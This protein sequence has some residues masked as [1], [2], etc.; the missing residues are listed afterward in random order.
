LIFDLGKTKFDFNDLIT[1]NKNLMGRYFI[2]GGIQFMSVLSLLFLIILS[3]AVFSVVKGIKSR[4][5]SSNGLSSFKKHIKS[6][7]L[8]ALVF[9][10]L[11]QV[12]GLVQI[13]DYLSGSTIETAASVLARGIKITF[14][15]TLYGIGIYLISI[16]I[17]VG[18]DFKTG[19]E[20]K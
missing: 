3:L 19:T 13:F 1:N 2:E 10:I 7:A 9:G 4:N 6:V 17:S 18:L 16:V 11:G 5:E 12:L 8:F 15:P 20:N 14:Y